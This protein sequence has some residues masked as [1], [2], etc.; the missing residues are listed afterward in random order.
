MG[1]PDGVGT[2]GIDTQFTNLPPGLV[3]NP[4]FKRIEGAPTIP[5]VYNIRAEYNSGG[6]ETSSMF[7]LNILGNT[8]P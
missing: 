5:G 8:L 3:F 1:V 7:T 2:A 6:I 4:A